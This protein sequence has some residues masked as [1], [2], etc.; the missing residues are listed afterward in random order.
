MRC[1][2][3]V[4]GQCPH[5]LATC[6]GLSGVQHGAV[7][8]TPHAGSYNPPSSRHLSTTHCPALPGV[9]C[10]AHNNNVMC[11]NPDIDVKFCKNIWRSGYGPCQGLST[12]NLQCAILLK[13]HRCHRCQNCQTLRMLCVTSSCHASLLAEIKAVSRGI[14]DV[15]HSQETLETRPLQQCN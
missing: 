1:L 2:G 9:M 3:A 10:Y 13:H 7:V 8:H 11:H 6:G 4:G 14:N 5:Y 15:C 12:V